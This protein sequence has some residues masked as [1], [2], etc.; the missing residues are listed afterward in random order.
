MSAD[1]VVVQYRPRQCSIGTDAVWSLQEE[2]EN[3][4]KKLDKLRRRLKGAQS[5]IKDLHDE[6]QVGALTLPSRAIVSPGA[7]HCSLLR[8]ARRR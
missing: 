6:F 2:L 3:K 5:E 8:G 7:R 4:T 1:V